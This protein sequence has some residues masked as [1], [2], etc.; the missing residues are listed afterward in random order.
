MPPPP[1]VAQPDP[2]SPVETGSGF[3][4]LSSSWRLQTARYSW[5]ASGEGDTRHVCLCGPADAI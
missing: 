5:R 2:V 1:D 4:Y 3:W